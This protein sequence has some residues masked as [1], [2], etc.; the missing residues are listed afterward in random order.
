MDSTKTIPWS[1]AWNHVAGTSSYWIGIV[2]V[3]V[4]GLL[5]Q[6]IISKIETK[7]DKDLNGVKLVFGVLAA[8]A[9]LFALLAA[10]SVISN[11]TTY[12][13]AG[14]NHWIY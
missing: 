3:I 8:M 11:N 7:M 6:F 1:M 12:E 13:F 14:R 2:A 10:P 5:A 4:G 9:L